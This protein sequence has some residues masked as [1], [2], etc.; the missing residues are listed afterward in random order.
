MHRI[1]LTLALSLP[2]T[3]C[4][5]GDGYA[6]GAPEVSAQEA[7]TSRPTPSR[8][9]TAKQP[10]T[11]LATFAGGCFW[12][13]E[14]PFEKLH[15]VT[16]V[17]SG[18]TGGKTPDPTYKQVC[19]GS[20]GHAEAVQV[21]YDPKRISYEDL[22]QVFWRQIDPTDAGGQFAD[23]G[24][25]YR[26]EIFAHDGAQRAAAETSKA[27]LAASGRF[28]KPI[29]VGISPA[30]RYYPAED[31]HQDYYKTNEKSYKRYRKG[32]GREGYLD[33]TWGDDYHF[34]PSH[35]AKRAGSSAWA[36]FEKPPVKTLK[37]KL[38]DMQ[39]RV[40]QEDATER[41]FKNEYW[42]NH[43]AGLYVDVV[44][45]EALFS[46]IDKFDSGT[47]WPSFTRPVE[48]ANV[49][50]KTDRKLGY[51]RTEVR[52][53]HAD[54]HL[55]HVFNDGPKPTGLRYCIN[56]A[57]LRFIPAE[58]LEREGYGQYLPSFGTETE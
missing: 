50:E 5:A 57:S 15:G 9:P 49:A 53:A 3:A 28:K 27:A 44:S 31:Y 24:N 12:C 25:Q 2:A 42:N 37:K 58:D 6:G 18:Y 13:M 30:A 14:G 11:A 23:R 34:V 51:S 41:P 32:S 55:G 20:T 36:N 56:S 48:K 35:V 33:K 45:G 17:I 1:L 46:S 52:S 22:L 4:E 38:T 29:V 26:A 21:H 39:Y 40:T 54:S 16:A 7:A 10:G 8:T 47:G 43:E 19:S